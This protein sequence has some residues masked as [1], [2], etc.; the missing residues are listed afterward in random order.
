MINTI[1]GA[2]GV[3][4]SKLSEMRDKMFSRIDSN[5]DD[6]I[7]K[8]EFGLFHANGPGGGK[9]ADE[10]FAETD[11]DQD[12]SISRQENEDAMKKMA[13]DGKV[14]RPP[15]GAPQGPPPGGGAKGVS[16]SGG[17]D[18][19]EDLNLNGI[20]DAE[21][22]QDSRLI[23]ENFLK[24]VLKKYNQNKELEEEDGTKTKA[25]GISM[26]EKDLYA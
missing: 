19:S 1:S 5:G 24:E 16:S 23:L 9:S 15:A 3:D 13:R 7:D 14:N 10:I 25:N 12:G 6:K 21:E 2:N 8:Q 22:K 11:T 4:F 18:E 26:L 17:S 20:P